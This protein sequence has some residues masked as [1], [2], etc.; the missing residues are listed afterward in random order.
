M[1]VLWRYSSSLLYFIWGLSK[2]PFI[3]TP[4]NIFHG[5][6]ADPTKLFVTDLHS[7]EDTLNLVQVTI[8][9]RL[10]IGR[11]GQS[12]NPKLTICRNI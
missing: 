3:I 10:R 2:S 6:H 11:D 8:Y 7:F 12:V 9:L 1:T 5:I 4:C